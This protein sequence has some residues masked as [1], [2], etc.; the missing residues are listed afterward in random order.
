MVLHIHDADDRNRLYCGL[1]FNKMLLQENETYQR[2]HDI[3][4]C[5]VNFYVLSDTRQTD[6]I[7]K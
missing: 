3:I 1:E 4:H 6:F 7:C 2:L 5:C